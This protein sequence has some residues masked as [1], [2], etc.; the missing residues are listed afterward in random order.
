MTGP[1]LNPAALTG[2]AAGTANDSSRLA[3]HE[4]L[5]AAGQRFEAI[6]TKMM[7]SSMRKA[8]LGEGLFDSKALD[9]F[10]D[11]QD[12][13]LAKSMAV[14]APMGIGEAMT[15]FLAGGGGATP[16][17]APDA[18]DSTDPKGGA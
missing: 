13:Q 5:E 4:N 12:D 7:L 11:M 6:F 18:V 10:R 1:T 8:S 15:S 16:I 14:N 17:A 9:Q 3:N 2:T